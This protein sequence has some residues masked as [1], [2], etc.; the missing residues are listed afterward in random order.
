[1]DA[2]SEAITLKGNPDAYKKTH[3]DMLQRHQEYAIM[4]DDYIEDCRI[5]SR[6]SAS[7][8]LQAKDQQ[9]QRQ[10][11]AVSAHVQASLSAHRTSV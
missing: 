8:S 2:H 3:E 4:L 7:K 1:M 9:S 6:D 10:L 11:L 5:E